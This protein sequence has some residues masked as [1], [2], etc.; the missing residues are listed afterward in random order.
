[1]IK[2]HERQRTLLRTN[3]QAKSGFQID[4]IRGHDILSDRVA[5]SLLSPEL[6]LCFSDTKFNKAPY[7]K[8]YTRF[9]L[10]TK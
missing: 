5:N 10:D 3:E 2:I 7:T 9:F 1:M 8:T 4:Q 6:K